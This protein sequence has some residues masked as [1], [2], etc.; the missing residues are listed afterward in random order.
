MSYQTIKQPVISE[1]AT[2]LSEHGTY[3]F[4][5][6]PRANKGVV[7]REIAARFGVD[8]VAVRTIPG[9]AK[10]VRR[11]TTRGWTTARKKALVTLRA[12]QKI[13]LA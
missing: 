6:S 5:V 4:F 8:V 13:E 3:A 11:G 9:R 7:A 10:R 12:G 2:R 1:K